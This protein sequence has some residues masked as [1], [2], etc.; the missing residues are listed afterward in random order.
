MKIA[1]VAQHTTSLA[2]D[3]RLRELSRSLAGKGHRVTVY[4]RKD[5]AAA[6][7]KAELEPGVQIELIGPGDKHASDESQ[8]LAQVPAFSQPLQTGG[9][10][11]VAGDNQV[12]IRR[13]DSRFERIAANR[14]VRV[15]LVNHVGLKQWM[16]AR[17][18]DADSKTDG[19]QCQTQACTCW[20]GLRGEQ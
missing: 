15:M 10:G 2:E 17:R 7:A 4:A 5:G 9:C 14:A 16:K 18:P 13:N 8:L 11:I 19:V 1:L 6:P 12:R 3:A 20:P